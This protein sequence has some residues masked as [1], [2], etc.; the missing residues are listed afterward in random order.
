M[1]GGGAIESNGDSAL[2]AQLD[3]SAKARDFRSP[4][5]PSRLGLV[6]FSFLNYL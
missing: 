5:P 6:R 3:D 1:Y 2:T 4:P